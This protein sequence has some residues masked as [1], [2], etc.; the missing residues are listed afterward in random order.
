MKIYTIHSESHDMWYSI[1]RD[2]LEANCKNYEISNRIVPQVSE[3]GDYGT[4]DIINFWYLKV[5]RILEALHTE[6]E[7]FLYS[8]TDVYVFK[9]FTEDL[10]NRL[11]NKDILIQYEKHRMGFKMV[12]AGFMYMKPND[13]VRKMF[14]WILKF[15]RSFGNDQAALNCYIRTTNIKVGILP[16]TYYSINYDN[17]NKVWEGEEVKITVED[18]FIA[19]IHWAIGLERRLDLLKMILK[20]YET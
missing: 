2:S 1:L 15:L 9:D 19:H 12:C 5:L 20:H 6:K 10:E 3:T 17:G 4:D 16:K 8:D 13:K 14:F 11:K 18:P 7:P